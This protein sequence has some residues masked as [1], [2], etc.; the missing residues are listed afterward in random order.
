MHSS[1]PLHTDQYL[2]SP[3]LCIL[4]PA[5]L[6]QATSGANWFPSKYLEPRSANHE[7]LVSAQLHKDSTSPVPIP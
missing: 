3:W 1:S 2:H 6:I 7:R 4:H 5:S